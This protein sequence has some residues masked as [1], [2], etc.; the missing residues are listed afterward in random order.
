MLKIFISVLLLTG[1]NL[2]AQNPGDIVWNKLFGGTEYDEANSVVYTNTEEFIAA[3]YTQSYGLGRWGNAYLF[4]ADSSGDSVWTRNF[5]WDGNDVFA[6]LVESSDGK[7]VATG[8]TD[9]PNDFENIYLVKVDIDG[10]LQ[11]EKNFGGPEKEVALSLVNADDGGLV[12][13]GVTRSFSVGEE[14]LFILKT[15]VDG[16][17]LWF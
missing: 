8:L 7:F 2:F 1:I 15:N 3:G 17:S 13:T 14:D 9:T 4:K 5:G 11:W 12:I 10:N 16:D 6:D